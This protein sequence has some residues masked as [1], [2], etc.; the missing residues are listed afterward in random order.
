VRVF[1]S[2]GVNGVLQGEIEKYDSKKEVDGDKME[3]RRGSDAEV[4]GKQI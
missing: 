1:F 3:K 2:K 4:V